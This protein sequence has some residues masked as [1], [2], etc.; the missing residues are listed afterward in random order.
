MDKK[1]NAKY[2][3][4]RLHFNGDASSANK[5]MISTGMENAQ[6]KEYLA[7]LTIQQRINVEYVKIHSTFCSKDY[8]S[9]TVVYNSIRIFNVQTAIQSLV[10]FFKM[11]D[12]LFLTVHTQE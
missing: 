2:Q 10:L 1:G 5:D 7:V 4:V 3:T 6:L 9:L 11:V 12:A 8:V